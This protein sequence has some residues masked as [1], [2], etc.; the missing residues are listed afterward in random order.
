MNITLEQIKQKQVGLN[1]LLQLHLTDLERAVDK[2]T[3]V[4]PKE[5]IKAEE[6]VAENGLLEEINSAQKSLERKIDKLNTLKQIL[7][8]STFEPTDNCIRTEQ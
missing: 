3:G 5:N 2:I 1:D 7:Y 4:Y 6:G 8:S